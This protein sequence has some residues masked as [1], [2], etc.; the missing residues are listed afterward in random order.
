LNAVSLIDGYSASRQL[1][2]ITD[3]NVP[4]DAAD[5]NSATPEN[6]LQAIFNEGTSQADEVVTDL[7]TENNQAPY[8]FENDGTATDTQYPGGPNQLDG[9]QLVDVGYFSAGTNSNKL[10]MKGDT[11][12]CGLVRIVNSTTDTLI[13]I[14]DLVPGAHRGYLAE[15]MTEM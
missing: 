5:I 9:L 7:I 11:F 14:V 8:P 15:P 6:W 12:P 13:V 4:E 1:P 3:P 10:Y 2:Q